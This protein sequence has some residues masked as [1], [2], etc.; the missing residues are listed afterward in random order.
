LLRKCEDVRFRYLPISEGYR[1]GSTKEY[2][3]FLK[4]AFGSCAEL[5]TQIS[6]SLDLK[7]VSME[8]AKGVLGKSEAVGQMLNKLI[9]SLEK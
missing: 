5:E 3:H 4:I 7:F 2:V 1:R 9:S 8:K 6:L